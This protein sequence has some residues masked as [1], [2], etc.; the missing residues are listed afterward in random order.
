M[1]PY[2]SR[3]LVI[4]LLAVNLG[5]NAEVRENEFGR[6]EGYRTEILWP[7]G[8]T[9]KLRV[10]AF[11]GKGLSN[12]ERIVGDF[13]IYPNSKENEMLEDKLPFF[14]NAEAKSILSRHPILGMMLIKNNKVVFEGY[15]YGSNKDTL[16]D[17]QSIA[18]PMTALAV[19]AL[20]DD[21]KLS[22]LDLKMGD[23]VPVLK[24]SPIGASTIKQALQMQCGH[25]FAWSDSEG[26]QSSAGRYAKIK[27]AV[28]D[29]G[30][31]DLYPYFASLP[32]EE[33]G[34]KFS[35]DPHCS[36]A[37]SML[38]TEISGKPLRKYFES[39]IWQKIKPRSKAAWLSP[40]KN[41]E[42]TSG[43]N[44]FY[45]SLRDFGKLAMLFMNGGRLD[46]EVIISERW[47]DKMH[48]DLVDVGAYP[49]DFKRY[50]YQT[51][52]RDASADSWF[53]G[54][55]WQGQRFYID[56]KNKS[57]MIIFALDYSHIKDSDALWNRF[58]K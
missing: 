54:L 23:V 5:V 36:D 52:V 1:N 28:Y 37:L 2:I 10:G 17:S 16:F 8:I 22:S 53:A 47:I 9:P 3:A 21:G 58:R 40:V 46:D 7:F 12:L 18:K 34:Y 15:Q 13:W 48:G 31:Q 50:G 44:T 4:S 29:T 27:F 51:C 45:A 11:T 35:Y 25:A 56:R 49:S 55:G 32:K 20:F 43:A 39:Q 42:I 41:P 30:A 14:Q 38:V 19:G 24:P 33:P 26:A 6:D 57:A